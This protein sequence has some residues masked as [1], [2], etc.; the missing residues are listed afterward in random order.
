MRSVL[1]VLGLVGSIGCSNKSETSCVPIV[2]S[3]F[4][5]EIPCGEDAPQGICLA[6]FGNGF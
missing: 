4:L 3:T 6:E 1:L 2:P 5:R